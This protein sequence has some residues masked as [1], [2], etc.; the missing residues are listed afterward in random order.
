MTPIETDTVSDLALIDAVGNRSDYTSSQLAALNLPSAIT[1]TQVALTAASITSVTAPLTGTLTNGS[2]TNDP[3]LTVKVDLTGTGA[4]AGDTVQLYNGTVTD[5]QLG[6][7]YT[8]T[9]A[10][11]SNG[12]ANVQT[13]PLTDGSSYIL[14]ARIT[15]AAGNQSAVSTNSFTVAESPRSTAE[16]FKFTGTVN[17]VDT[18]LTSEFAVGDPISGSFTFDPASPDQY[19]TDPTVGIYDFSLAYSVTA[20]GF[21]SSG[22]GFEF[23]VFD[24]LVLAPAALRDQYRAALGSAGPSVNGLSYN[25]FSLDLFTTSSD[26]TALNS[27]ALPVTPPI[28]N[29]FQFNQLRFYF[30]DPNNTVTGVDYVIGSLSSLTF[31]GCAPLSLSISSVTDNVAP[32][33]GS[34]AN[35][36]ITNDPDPIV[37]ISLSGSG[38][39]AGDAVQLYNGTG[40][41]SPLGSS[42]TLASIDISNGFADVQTGTLINGSTYT[43]TVRITDAA[44]NQSAVSTNSF[45]VTEDTTAPTVTSVVTTGAGITAGSGDL[46]AGSIATLTVNLS[47]AVTVAGGTPTLTLNDGGAATYIGGSGSSALTFSYTVG[48][49]QNTA[50]LTVTAF[51]PGTANIKNGAGTAANLT[52]VVTNPAGILQI[53]TTTHITQI[54]ND[55]FLSNV[56]GTGPELKVGGVPVTAGEFPGWTMIGAVQIAGGGYDIA[57]KNTITGQYTAW[58]TDSKGNYLSNLIT[59]VAGN[60]AALEALETTFNQ[61][62]NS[63]GTVGITKVVIQTDGSTALTEVANNFYL[64]H[65]GTGPELKVRGVP[66]T[67]GEFPGWTMIG[68]V[69]I[70]GGGYDIALKNTITGQYT[71]WSTDSKGNYLSNLIT[72]VAGNS[73]ALEALET[74]FNQDLNGDGTVGITKVVIQTDGSTALTEVANNFY[75]YH[76]GTGPELKVRGVPVTAGEF[77]GWTMIGAVQIAGGGYDIALKNTITGQYTAWSTDSKGNYL[78]N[79]ITRVAGNSA[80]LEA[81]E[82][83]FNQDLNGDGAVGLY[84]APSTSLMI[85]SPLSGT[86]GSATIGTRAT[87]ELAAADSASVTFSSSTGILKLDNPSTFSGTIFD[88]TGNGTLSGSD[89]IDLKG[90]NFSS[91]HDTYSNGV[92]TVTDGTHTDALD[93]NGSY[94]LANFKFAND[95]NGD[96]IVYDPPVPAGQSGNVPAINNDPGSTNHPAATALDRQMALFS[97]HMSSAFP[98]SAFGDGGPSTV[99]PSEFGGGQLGTLVQPVV[100]HWPQS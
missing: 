78:S 99:I 9:G 22:T 41:D 20:G 92:L 7:S 8:L 77:P 56:S 76:N 90:V 2:S 44:G 80:A 54:G 14:T 40:T 71:A 28:I 59:R 91:V 57:L 42:Y 29:D 25:G 6:S 60:S 63:D 87:L 68:A 52:G 97:Q 94:T 38:A 37:Q 49:G 17:S 21:A 46:P 4:L 12:F 33:I 19:P 18:Q 89:Q 50:D 83:T 79:L 69:Q 95:G 1:F 55:Y 70:A 39:I 100:S 36:G 3:D 66:V 48:A 72:R 84:A 98:S 45:V 65:N 16:I 15:D 85:S 82:T 64:Y 74:T 67:A 30:I 96:T 24:N 88:F 11:I 81:L 32:L 35:G 31:V 86:S 5:N 10:D 58:S 27:D 75:L 47:E 43:L 62:L 73:A 13:G 61:D 26:P 53:D 23:N 51:N 34:I 93:F